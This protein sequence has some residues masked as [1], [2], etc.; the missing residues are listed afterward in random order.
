MAAL[1]SR[2]GSQLVADWRDRKHEALR[3]GESV[4]RLNVAIVRRMDAAC[5]ERGIAF[6]LAA[7]PDRL[8]Y[9]SKPR[10][11][12]RFLES[13]QAEGIT[14]VDMA[15]RFVAL[16]QPFSAVSLDRIGHLSPLGHS[17]ASE[18]LESEIASHTHAPVATAQNQPPERLPDVN[19]RTA[20]RSPRTGAAAR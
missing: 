12:E 2:S 14:V 15:A 18:V 5:R 20:R 1:D 19:D 16:G 4:L 17:I 13:V 7:F 3:E 6:I 8:S 9:R 11:A 10:L